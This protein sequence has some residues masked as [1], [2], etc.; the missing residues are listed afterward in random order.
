MQSYQT[1]ILFSGTTQ[2]NSTQIVAFDAPT[3]RLYV[4]NSIGGKPNILSLANPAAVAGVATIDIRTYG[5]I[6]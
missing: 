4:A 6:N 3:K 1:G 2:I 5:S